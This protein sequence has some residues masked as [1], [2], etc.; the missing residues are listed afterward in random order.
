MLLLLFGFNVAVS[1][2]LASSSSV[3]SGF[4][5]S[6]FA[7]FL[8]GPPA[9]FSC[10]KG[11]P[12]RFLSCCYPFLNLCLQFREFTCGFFSYIVYMLSGFN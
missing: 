4:R 12:V 1:C 5:Y 11:L 3:S 2:G 8:D 9:P 10:R 6:N 7:E